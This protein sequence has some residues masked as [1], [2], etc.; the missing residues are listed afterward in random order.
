MTAKYTQNRLLHLLGTGV[1]VT[2]KLLGIAM[3]LV[4][5]RHKQVLD[6]VRLHAKLQKVVQGVSRQVDEQV[7]A[8]ECLRA[9]A[10]VYTAK[11]PCGRATS[12]V[13]KYGRK[14]LDGRGAK[15][16][17]LHSGSPFAMVFFIIPNFTD[18]VNKMS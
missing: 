17:K 9:R 8:H 5:M 14:A 11:L 7:L 12:A 13:A 10:H 2:P 6:L 4:R 16:S 18:L 1:T 15:I 3:V